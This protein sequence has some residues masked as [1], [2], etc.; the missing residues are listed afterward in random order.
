MYRSAIASAICSRCFRRASS[1]IFASPLSRA[2]STASR[3]SGVKH[4]DPGCHPSRHSEQ[5][6]NMQDVHWPQLSPPS[7]SITAA[8]HRGQYTRSV[9]ASSDRSKVRRS[10]RVNCSLGSSPCNTEGA[11]GVTHPGSG[12]VSAARLPSLTWIRACSPRH[13]LQKRW[14]HPP[15][16]A[17]RISRPST[18]LKQIPQA[19]SVAAYR[20]ARSTASCRSREI[21]ASSG[22]RAVGTPRLSTPESMP[23]FQPQAT[24]ERR[25]SSPPGH[26]SSLTA[27]SCSQET[28][29]KITTSPGASAHCACSAAAAVAS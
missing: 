12:H 5:K 27:C 14:A 3:L 19:C 20:R 10:Q 28:Q 7:S 16:L 25:D 15:G 2:C 29:R 22:P 23:S 13:S 9:M 8:S 26:Q 1:P 6:T 17:W 18:S 24:G 21:S 4:V 11:R